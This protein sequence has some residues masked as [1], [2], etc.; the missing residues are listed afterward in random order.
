MSTIWRLVAKQRQR[1]FVLLPVGEQV[2]QIDQKPHPRSDQ[3][4]DGQEENGV[5]GHG[6]KREHDACSRDNQSLDEEAGRQSLAA[7]E[8]ENAKAQDV[9]CADEQGD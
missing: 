6:D 1:P 5:Q 9:E 4:D 7:Q 8:G 2:S 3:V